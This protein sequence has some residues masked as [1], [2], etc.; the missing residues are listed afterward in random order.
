VNTALRR[1]QIRLDARH[2][3]CR[4]DPRAQ[5]YAQLFGV[6]AGA[7]IV[8]PAFDL[9]V[10]DPAVLAARPGRRRRASCG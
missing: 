8:V 6:V 3:R 10:P 4:D 2:T 7:V 1:Y 5:F 9:L